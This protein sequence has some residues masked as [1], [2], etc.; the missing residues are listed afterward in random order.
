MVSVTL[1]ITRC[2]WRSLGT[3]GGHCAILEMVWAC[4]HGGLLLRPA[5]TEVAGLGMVPQKWLAQ[6]C[7]HGVYWLGPAPTKVAGSGLFLQM[8]LAQVCSL[9]ITPS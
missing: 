3:I 9:V 4:S 8:F 1:E 6:V 5:L 7:P 2:S